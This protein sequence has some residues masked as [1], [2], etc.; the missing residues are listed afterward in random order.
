MS[1]FSPNASW[2]TT[3]P[4]QGPEDRGKPEGP[5]EPAGTARYAT[6][7]PTITSG[8]ASDPALSLASGAPQPSSS[9][10]ARPSL[11]SPGDAAPLRLAHTL[12]QP[13]IQVPSATV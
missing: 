6:L 8:T 1:E 2:I 3:T 9:L 13:G 4:G 7:V 5:A 12:R 10:V 11:L